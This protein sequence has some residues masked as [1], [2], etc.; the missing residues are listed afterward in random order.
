MKNTTIQEEE[1]FDCCSDTEGLSH[2]I[3]EQKAREMKR[4]SLFKSTSS[5]SSIRTSLKLITPEYI[6]SLPNVIGLKK[7]KKSD[8]EFSNLRLIQE[9]PLFNNS[10]TKS[11]TLKFSQDSLHLS[12]TGKHIISVYDIQTLACEVPVLFKPTP[13]IFSYDSAEI[14]CTSWSADNSIFSSSVN[15]RVSQWHIDKEKPVAFFE[16]PGVVCAVECLPQDSEI[17]VTACSDLIIRVFSTCTGVIGYYQAVSSPS[18][19]AF[20]EASKKMAVGTHKGEVM[21]Y[22][23]LPAGKFRLA[24]V[25]VCRNS[26]GIHSRGRRVTGIEVRGEYLVVSTN[27]S[28]IRMYRYGVLMHKYKGHK[29]QGIALPVSFS[30]DM[31]H[32][33]SGSQNGDIYI[34][35]SEQCLESAIKVRQVEHFQVRNKRSDE[36]AMFLSTK[37]MDLFRN[38][39]RS[40]GAFV[41]HIIISAGAQGNLRIFANFP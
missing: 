26:R 16:H 35:N 19:L 22:H 25:L 5:I 12:V 38:I 11:W 6:H 23:S 2:T 1:F 31:K 4:E 7:Y 14:T 29:N 33:L 37:V 10:S 15:G 32:I 8:F 36:F 20:D 39:Y 13:K 41:K 30:E 34:W 17:F 9:I 18:C 24:Q 28:R 27:D 40:Q 3:L 21:V